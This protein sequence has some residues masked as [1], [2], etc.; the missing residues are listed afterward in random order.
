MASSTVT[1]SSN[2]DSCSYSSK[3][4]TLSHRI[5]L[6]IPDQVSRDKIK[7]KLR[8][9][10]SLLSLNSKTS[11]PI[12][13]NDQDESFLRQILQNCDIK[14]ILNPAKG[15][16]LPLINDVNH[17]SSI[18]LTSHVWQIGELICKKVALGSIDDV[19][20]DRK[21]LSLQELQKFKIMNRKFNGIP[22]L[23]KS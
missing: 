18:Q 2:D 14:R 22:Q 13:K 19:T 6:P 5:S 23:L 16:M 21:S 8:N 12:N 11:P 3:S 20:S 17:L 4:S 9:S 1:S 15:D 7:N 10:N